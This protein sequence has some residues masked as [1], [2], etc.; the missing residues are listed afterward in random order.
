MEKDTQE[1][2]GFV[3]TERRQSERVSVPIREFGKALST[4]KAKKKYL[5][6]AMNSLKA[7]IKS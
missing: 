2:L 6:D 1:D 7:D 4:E 5:K 3:G